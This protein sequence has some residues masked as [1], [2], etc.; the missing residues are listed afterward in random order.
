MLA[1]TSKVT[2][3]EAN[4]R[5]ARQRSLPVICSIPFDQ[6][7]GGVPSEKNDERE[8]RFRTMTGGKVLLPASSESGAILAH[9]CLGDLLA[10]HVPAEGPRPINGISM[11]C[12]VDQVGRE[13]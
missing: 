7:V 8:V 5:V 10:L 13:S 3:S 6:D 11:R 4:V 1:N 12:A 2:S 9:A